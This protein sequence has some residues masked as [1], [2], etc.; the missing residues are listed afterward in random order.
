M[1]KRVKVMINELAHKRGLSL[2]KLS[3]L[4]GVRRAAL[5]E[6]ASGVKRDRIEFSHIEKIAETFD[7]DD[8]REIITIVD[9]DDE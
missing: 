8:I 6:L 5:S 7:I 4:T 9:V 2:N 3:D 1:T